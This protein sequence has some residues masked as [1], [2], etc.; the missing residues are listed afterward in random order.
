MFRTTEDID[1][2]F[3]KPPEPTKKK[4]KQ[5]KKCS[6]RQLEALKK[7]RENRLKKKRQN[8]KQIHDIDDIDIDIDDLEFKEA[9]TPPNTPVKKNNLS[10]KEYLNK[11]M[12]NG[13]NPLNINYTEIIKHQMTLEHQRRYNRTNFKKKPVSKLVSKPEIKKPEI[14]KPEPKKQEPEPEIKEK[15]KKYIKSNKFFNGFFD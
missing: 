11:E 9:P 8:K 14:K 15:P 10:L 4:S 13:N 12:L 5:K 3:E 6:N 1:V 2:I 7:G